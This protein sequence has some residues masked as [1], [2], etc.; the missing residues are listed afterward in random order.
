MFR[1]PRFVKNGKNVRA[2]GVKI[3]FNDNYEF[4]NSTY[5]ELD[6]VA[7][8]DDSRLS[9]SPL[10]VVK[11]LGWNSD[12]AAFAFDAIGFTDANKSI[13]RP[14][15]P[16]P[17]EGRVCRRV[18]LFE[19]TVKPIVSKIKLMLKY[20]Q[21]DQEGYQSY[22][23]RFPGRRA[24]GP[25]E[26]PFYTCTT[27]HNEEHIYFKMTSY[28]ED[29]QT[30]C[31]Q[32]L[33]RVDFGNFRRSLLLRGLNGTFN[34]PKLHFA[35]EVPL[36]GSGENLHFKENS[37]KVGGLDATWIGER[38]ETYRN[39]EDFN[40]SN[41]SGAD[42]EYL[43][44]FIG[45]YKVVKFQNFSDP[46]HPADGAIITDNF[47]AGTYDS[48]TNT[49]VGFK[50]DGVNLVQDALNPVDFLNN[51][52]DFSPNNVSKAGILKVKDECIGP[53]GRG[54][55]FT[56]SNGLYYDPCN[57]NIEVSSNFE[58]VKENYREAIIEWMKAEKAAYEA[59]GGN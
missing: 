56:E 48:A 24:E 53:D 26:P 57:N 59:A 12:R 43:A 54:M 28:I 7:G 46:F 1:S 3:L 39:G 13:I 11:M 27:C 40:L 8:Q 16:K 19:K 51:K 55:R 9:I 6:L 44:K 22:T 35:Q 5:S 58:R 34:H 15:E 32:A 49:Y 52:S 18:D 33:S 29:S 25:D 36:E 37:S 50:N 4:S 38:F 21:N 41:Y 31:D 47:N 10:V 20:E 30:L 14:D 23:Q 17:I 45:Q 2:K 42:R